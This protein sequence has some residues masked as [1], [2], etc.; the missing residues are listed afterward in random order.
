MGGLFSQA[1]FTKN[2]TD[3][4]DQR[5]LYWFRWRRALDDELEFWDDWF[6]TK[7]GPWPE[8]YVRRLD[9]H[10]ELQ[11]NLKAYLPPAEGKAVSILDVGSGPI[12][13]LG[14]VWGDRKIKLTA[15]DALANRYNALLREHH[16]NPPLTTVAGSAETLRRRFPK[17]SFDLVYCRNALDH[18]HSPLRAIRQ[19]LA[20]TKP[21]GL[22]VLEH[23]ENEA[24][25]SGYEGLH[26]WNFDIQDQRLTVWNQS[27]RIDVASEIRDLAETRWEQKHLGRHWVEAVMTKHPRGEKHRVSH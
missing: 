18:C 10:G 26:Q 6:S 13:R 20:V 1:S 22:V 19:M 8:D 17:D 24:E 23:Y 14:Y 25:E 12:T 7:G 27:A 5:F 3:R 2:K 16:I 21:G 4:I 11:E 9:A 15:V